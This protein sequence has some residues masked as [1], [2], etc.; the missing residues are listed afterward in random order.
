MQ[1]VMTPLRGFLREIRQFS[2]S[3]FEFQNAFILPSATS[4]DSLTEL[5]ALESM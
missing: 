1:I 4:T 3:Q 2:K 5:V